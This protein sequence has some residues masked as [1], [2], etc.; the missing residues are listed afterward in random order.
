MRFLVVAGDGQDIFQKPVRETLVI[1][2]NTSSVFTISLNISAKTFTLSGYNVLGASV[3]KVYSFDETTFVKDL[4]EEIQIDISTNIPEWTDLDF[5]VEEKFKYAKVIYLS[6]TDNLGNALS[7]DGRPGG[8]TIYHCIP[9]YINP[10]SPDFGIVASIDIASRDENGNSSGLTLQEFHDALVDAIGSWGILTDW[11]DTPNTPEW[12]NLPVYPVLLVPYEQISNQSLGNNEFPIPYTFTARQNFYTTDPTSASSFSIENTFSSIIPD[13]SLET[14]SDLAE[15]INRIT[16]MNPA[17]IVNNTID[18]SGSSYVGNFGYDIKIS[19]N[20]NYIVVGKPSDSESDSTHS[21][22]YV[23]QQSGNSWTQ[24]KDLGVSLGSGLFGNFGKS[25]TVNGSG[26]EIAI[27]C[28]RNNSSASPS[29]KVVTFSGLGNWNTRQ[30]IDVSSSS[31]GL[32]GYSVAISSDGMTLVVGCPSNF[33]YQSPGSCYIYTKQS[34]SWVLQKK[35]TPTESN[36]GNF[37]YSVSI[38]G[39]G[40]VVS[41][42]SPL[43]NSNI[44]ISGSVY[45]YSNTGSDWELEQI[46]S[47]SSSYKGLFGRSVSLSDDGFT[48]AVGSPLSSPGSSYAASSLEVGKVFVFTRSGLSWTEFQLI[49]PTIT[50]GFDDSFLGMFGHCVSVNTDGT[51]LAVGS[52]FGYNSVGNVFTFGRFS[53]TWIQYQKINTPLDVRSNSPRFG[54]SVSMSENGTIVASKPSESANAVSSIRPYFYVY[55]ISSTIFTRNFLN[56][57]DGIPLVFFNAIPNA[58]VAGTSAL[59]IDFIILTN[60]NA[61]P[62]ST[63]TGSTIINTYPSFVFADEIISDTIVIDLSSTGTL[64]DLVNTINSD[65]RYSQFIYAYLVDPVFARDPQIAIDPKEIVSLLDS[66]VTLTGTVNKHLSRSYSFDQ[67][68]T[69]FSLSGAISN[70]WASAGF[71]VSIDPVSDLHSDAISSNLNAASFD[72]S[73][74]SQPKYFNGTVA[75][76]SNPISPVTNVKINL[77][78]AFAKGG[79]PNTNTGIQVAIGGYESNGTFYPNDAPNTFFEPVYNTSFPISFSTTSADIIYLLIRTRE[80]LD[81]TSY[82]VD[83]SNYSGLVTYSNGATPFSLKPFTPTD[84]K[85]TNFWDQGGE[86]GIPVVV[87]IP[88]SAAVMN[89]SIEDSKE[90]Q[91]IN[92]QLINAPSSLT[93]FGFLAINRT[94]NSQSQTKSKVA[95]TFGLVL[96]NRGSWDVLISPEAILS[97]DASGSVSHLGIQYARTTLNDDEGYDFSIANTIPEEIATAISISPLINNPQVWVLRIEYGVKRYLSQLRKSN[98]QDGCSIDIDLNVTGRSTGVTGVARVSIFYDYT[99]VYDIGLC[100]LF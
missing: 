57:I 30:I 74:G 33:Y 91:S 87:A 16:L 24:V 93:D 37:G 89:V 54:R 81:S 46:L 88:V 67:Y 41:I 64:G 11:L 48:I 79:N 68:P 75:G 35:I 77:N 61:V 44:G 17:W 86:T 28:P 97:V 90:L 60:P 31:S 3:E 96:D 100:D 13:A 78:V 62:L 9:P 70:D 85:F 43:D 15:Y 21:S 80:N 7:N 18:P 6:N 55:K 12:R 34:G 25:V 51:I 45:I 23:Y 84:T 22:A 52:P 69:L 10:N 59:S 29:G 8:E 92:L 63:S 42:G 20:G 47:S 40:S 71:V 82:S 36:T 65:N 19:L 98:S 94:N 76:L 73:Q 95:Q 56:K 53:D 2:N 5:Y 27:G 72:I 26:S 4:V 38:S 14:I 1:T 66:P 39:D 99:C 58:S 32:F 50:G 49:L 83:P